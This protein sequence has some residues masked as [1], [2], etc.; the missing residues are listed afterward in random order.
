MTVYINGVARPVPAV[1]EDVIT[2]PPPSRDQ[3]N[4]I[5]KHRSTG[6]GVSKIYVCVEN[7][8]RGYQWLQI[9]V[10]T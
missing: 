9:A 2:L 7:S 3:L 6:G 10:S 5:V 8:E 1:A 4:K